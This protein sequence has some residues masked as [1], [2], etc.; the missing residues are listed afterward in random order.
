MNDKELYNTRQHDA[1]LREAIARRAQKR[2]QM[3]A[4]L[5]ERLMERVEMRPPRPSITPHW[6][7]PAMAACMAAAFFLGFTL[8]GGNIQRPSLQVPLQS[9]EPPKTVYASVTDTTYQDPALVDEYIAKLAAQYE[10]V[11]ELPDSIAITDA[12]AVSFVYM[13]PDYKEVD[14]LAHMQQV[15]C[16]YSNGTPGYLLHMTNDRL[17]FELQ[18]ATKGRQYL[19]IVEELGPNT[20]LYGINSPL[21][22][23][24]SYA[25]YNDYRERCI[26]I[27]NKSKYCNF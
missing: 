4:D 3:P 21:T 12:G 27:D 26:F 24:I 1:N 11:Q 20:L 8:F 25:C 14:V 19:W 2:P 23:T 13:F 10:V 16:W 22:A 15:A 17:L 9:S 18:D 5:N 7:W 6:V